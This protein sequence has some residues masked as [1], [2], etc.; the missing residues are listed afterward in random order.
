M[1]SPS[2]TWSRDRLESV[3]RSGQVAENTTASEPGRRAT[4]PTVRMS[5]RSDGRIGRVMSGTY[6]AVEP[7]PKVAP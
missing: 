3:S 7:G 6:N 5:W 2:W 4:A 1:P